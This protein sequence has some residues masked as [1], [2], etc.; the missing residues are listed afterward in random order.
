MTTPCPRCGGRVTGR[1]GHDPLLDHYARGC[2]GVP[3]KKKEEAA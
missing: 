1:R 3:E 2:P